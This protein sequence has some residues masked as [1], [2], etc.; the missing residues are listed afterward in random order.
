MP[1]VPRP[2]KDEEDGCVCEEVAENHRQPERPAQGQ[3]PQVHPGDHDGGA[4]TTT[5][6]GQETIASMDLCARCKTSK[7]W[8]LPGKLDETEYKAVQ[9]GN[10]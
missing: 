3:G 2:E 7:R 9:H 8:S 5:Q 10:L 4:S 1:V 6:V